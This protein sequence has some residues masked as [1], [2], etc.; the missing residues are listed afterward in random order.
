MKGRPI[1]Q[2][3]RLGFNIKNKIIPQLHLI[4]ILIDFYLVVFFSTFQIRNLIFLVYKK[5]VV[6]N[7]FSPQ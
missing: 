6:E 3:Q 5:K 2:S 1:P 7:F 4:Q